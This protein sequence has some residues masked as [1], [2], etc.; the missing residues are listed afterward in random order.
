MKRR[1]ESW[2]AMKTKQWSC[3]LFMSCRR[4]FQSLFYRGK[5]LHSSVVTWTTCGI[6]EW[7]LSERQW[8]IKKKKGIVLSCCFPFTNIC[9]ELLYI[10]ELVHLH[11]IIAITVLSLWTENRFPT[12]KQRPFPALLSKMALTRNPRDW[13]WS[14]LHAKQTVNHLCKPLSPCSIIKTGIILAL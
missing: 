7:R 4:V 1:C 11:Q 8:D 5:T 9:Y 10:T 2:W 13:S 6:N 14:F 12:I 3:I